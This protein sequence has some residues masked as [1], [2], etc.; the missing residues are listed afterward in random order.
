MSI[1]APTPT[2]SHDNASLHGVVEITAADAK[3]LRGNSQSSFAW[4]AALNW[5][6]SLA[7]SGL[8]P[9]YLRRLVKEGKLVSRPI[10]P[11]GS[12][13]VLRAELDR[14]LKEILSAEMKS[15]GIEEDFDFG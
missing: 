6:Q 11:R 8:A 12:N 7:Y 2:A 10:G 15:T 13:I 4:P 1:F 9:A 14:I 5:R 3:P